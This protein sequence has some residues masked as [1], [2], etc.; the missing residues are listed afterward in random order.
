M[1]WTDEAIILSVRPHG[2]TA[3]VVELLDTLGWSG[4]SLKARRTGVS[5]LMKL[6]KGEAAFAPGFH[7]DETFSLG[8]TPA[9]SAE[10]YLRP[11]SVALVQAGRL[12]ASG[13][14][15]NSPRSAAE[16]GVAANGVGAEESPEALVLREGDIA[17][18]DLLKA[19]DTDLDWVRL[20]TRL[21]L[22]P[23]A[24]Q[25]GD[26]DAGATNRARS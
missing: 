10:G 1:D 12:P 16:Y 6:D 13:G 25:A 23:T 7:L 14:T 26:R 19:L 11:A 2:E 8:T 20:H 3:A 22:R 17:S 4:F 21:T 5:S 18:A 15:L 24:W 9:F